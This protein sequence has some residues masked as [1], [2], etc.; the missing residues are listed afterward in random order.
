MFK[1]IGLSILGFILIIGVLF[2]VGVLD[3]EFQKFFRPRQENVNREVFENTQSYVHGKTQD[4]SRYYQQYQNAD[5]GERE[6]IS[7]VIQMQFSEFD[8]DKIN[9]HQLKQFLRNTRGY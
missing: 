9:N 2:G 4:L 6:I 7:N 3:L 1:T 8:A 5:A